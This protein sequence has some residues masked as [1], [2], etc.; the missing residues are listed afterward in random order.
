[1]VRPLPE[2][3][4]RCRLSVEQVCFSIGSDDIASNGEHPASFAVIGQDRAMLAL[5]LALSIRE[6]G[7]NVFV[8]GPAG[9]GK[10]TA[11]FQVL[12]E[13]PPDLDR[14]RDVALRRNFRRDE[15]P[16]VLYF[17]RGK[18]RVFKERMRSF[19]D[20]LAGSLK[21]FFR[22]D[23]FK[24]IRDK[25][26]LESE[27]AE[28]Q[29]IFDFE[30]RLTKEGFQM[31]QIGEEDEQK[32][33]I[34]PLVKGEVSDFDELQEMVS[35]GELPKSAYEQLREQYF[36]LTDELQELFRTLQE[37]R[38]ETKDKVTDL[39]LQIITPFIEENIN[40]L[41]DE[42]PYPEVQSYLK[43]LAEDLKHPHGPVV[44]LMIPD[45]SAEDQDGEEL[46]SQAPESQLDRMRAS[47]DINILVDHTDTKENPRIFEQYPDSIKLFGSI[48][49][50]PEGREG[51]PLH[52][53]VRA[54]SVLL[55][56]GGYLILRAED[57]VRDEEAYVALKRVLSEGALEIRSATGPMGQQ[58]PG[59][60]PE[61]I[62]IDIKVVVMAPD[63]LYELL[64]D[65]DE[66]FQKLFKVP[67]DFDWTVDRT[68][69]ICQAYRDFFTMIQVEGNL[70]PL[71]ESA[72]CA[73]LEYA[74]RDAEFRTKLSTRFSVL[75]DLV[76]EAGHWARESASVVIDRALIEK[77]IETRR[78]LYSLPEEKIDEQ[79]VGGEILM[80][81]SGT[82]VGRL[83][84]LAV[85]D[86]GFY[87]FGRPTVI[88]AQAAPGSEGVINV[89]HEAGLSGEIHDKGA[90]I[91]GSFIQA[92]YAR[93]FPLG[94]KA[95]ICFE[96]SYSEVD[97]D[98][99]SS[100]EVY[101]L[102]SA[103]A[104][105]PLRQDLAITGSVNQMGQIQPV[106]GVIEKIEG[107]FQIC[108]K[109]GLS[110]TQGVLI[111]AQNVSNLVLRREVQDAVKSGLFHIYAVRTVYEGLEILTG[112]HAGA[113][114][115]KGLFPEGTINAMVDRALRE[116]ART[117]KEFGS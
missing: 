113:R 32:T 101:A 106:G 16:A 72:V 81:L 23:H 13:L 78:F 69:A 45:T 53:L 29:L 94:I 42:F 116:M 48:E 117:V 90:F 68:P 49:S 115:P 3:L 107:F 57:L 96:Q 87:S 98:S 20:A 12:A 86:R 110:G 80:Q 103:I 34:L 46:T 76:H 58:G 2:S 50:P 89:E 24:R 22:H 82:S 88:S 65:R 18:A 5:R 111:P 75:A 52:M 38:H 85:M 33:D 74:A 66:D 7:Y 36:G 112:L 104:G 37:K 61:P 63:G 4:D 8:S 51:T 30:G 109:M 100:A 114:N 97:G 71:D 17:P 59:I 31:V 44:R 83:N 55:A 60:K 105:I 95:S 70:A 39:R 62:R 91:V 79:I 11:V 1:M 14:L 73:L 21:G 10:R 6:K 92:N 64:Y 54:G 9:T 99:A 26:L 35:K 28:Q 27:S 40:R 41:I 84:A 102:L 25:L 56:S 77:T 47:C 43:E 67:A 19:V 93:D 108:R 15:A